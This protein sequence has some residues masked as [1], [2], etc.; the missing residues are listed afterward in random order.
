MAFLGVKVP[1]EAARLLS[2]VDYGGIG[3]R[4]PLDHSHITLLHLGKKVPLASI[5]KAIIPIFEAV[6]RC[7]P[8]TV[9]T[10]R[11]SVFTP[12][13]DEGTVPIICP[14]DSPAL[15]ELRAAVGASCDA[16]GVDFSKKF[17][18]YTPH[19]TL[20]YSKDAST[21]TNW[22]G[23]IPFTPV[24]WGVHEI[25]MWGGDEGDKRIVVTFPMSITMSKQGLNRAFV[26]LAQRWNTSQVLDVANLWSQGQADR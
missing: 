20:A 3:E 24:E 9:S 18:D 6:S 10:S 4:E 25:V 7:A 19:V 17:P 11:V 26:Q 23:D 13:P 1:H 16:A 15:H 5:C 21:Y 2:E 14:I 8:F 22:G 12:H